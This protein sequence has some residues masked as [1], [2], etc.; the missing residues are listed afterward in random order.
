LGSQRADAGVGP[1]CL[2]DTAGHTYQRQRC[3]DASQRLFR[4]LEQYGLPR[5]VAARCSSG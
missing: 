4:L 1:G 2:R 5:K 3:E